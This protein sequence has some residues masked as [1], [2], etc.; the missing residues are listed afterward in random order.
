MAQDPFAQFS[1]TPG[2][3]DPFADV[4]VAAP[5]ESGVGGNVAMGALGLAGLAGAAFL[6]KKPGVIGKA[7]RS[8]N[9]L[10]QQ[11]MLTGMA[12]PKSVM[13]GAGAAVESALER[14]SMSPIKEFFS[15]ET[16]KD[17]YKAFKEGGA[18]GP[19]P[20]VDVAAHELP[21]WMN[22]P[23]RLLGAGDV[24]S[25]NALERSGMTTTESQAALLQKP[26]PKGFEA[27]ESDTGRYVQPF[28]RT[29]FNQWFS[30]FEKVKRAE[31][32][33]AGN[34]G[35]RRTLGIYTGAGVLHGAAT[36]DDKYPVSVPFGVA[37]S[38]RY[39]LPYAAGALVGRGL[40]GGY[41]GGGIA[42]AALPTSEYSLEQEFTD[43]FKPFTDPAI[44][45]VFAPK[46]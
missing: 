24:A 6:A 11:L 2:G 40:A 39:G 23:G 43:P 29:P 14:G 1:A 32:G 27:L 37:A 15:P 33:G 10:R 45:R 46:K 38:A 9:A 42:G 34:E 31:Q 18:V 20:G 3:A 44:A 41:G 16:V 12:V 28:R 17:A 21:N 19:T 26:L 22:L 8:A 13:G 35:I 5:E 30:G 7:L 4:A 25:R 36:A